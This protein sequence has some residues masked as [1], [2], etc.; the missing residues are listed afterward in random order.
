MTTGSVQHGGLFG[1][2]V[3][4][5]DDGFIDVFFK[6]LRRA[7]E[8]ALIADVFPRNFRFSAVG[9]AVSIEV[10]ARKQH[11]MRR[12]TAAVLQ[13]FALGISVENHQ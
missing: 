3:T 12:R 2:E 9:L 8:V 1:A 13:A 4:A 6:I 10:D 11:G 5:V 7:D